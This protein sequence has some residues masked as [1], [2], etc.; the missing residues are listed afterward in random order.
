MAGVKFSVPIRWFCISQLS[1]YLPFFLLGAM[2]ALPVCRNMFSRRGS[3][4][5]FILITV[6]SA[7]C[8]VVRQMDFGGVIN[9]VSV[10]L[11]CVTL[12]L[13]PLLFFVY[14][15]GCRNLRDSLWLQKLDHWSMGIYIVHH[16]YIQELNSLSPFHEC[17]MR[18]PYLYPLLLFV[19]VLPLSV[20]TVWLMQQ[21]RWGKYL[22]G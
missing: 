14:M 3:L 17:M 19:I 1:K 2:L 15:R 10:G 20:A 4:A 18:Q 8:I 11:S 5:A 7:L 12:P 22:V 6:I 9:H 16:I 21:L 13:M